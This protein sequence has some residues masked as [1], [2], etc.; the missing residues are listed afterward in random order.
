MTA[1]PTRLSALR[2]LLAALRSCL[3]MRVRLH[4]TYQAVHV[5]VANA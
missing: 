2:G 3:R 1:T 4:G 5:A